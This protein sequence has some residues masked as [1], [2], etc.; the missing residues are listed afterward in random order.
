M[1]AGVQL[2]AEVLELQGGRLVIVSPVGVA[3]EVE[4]RIQR[5]FNVANVC[6]AHIVAEF[7]DAD[8]V[9]L[10]EF[11]RIADAAKGLCDSFEAFKAA[12]RLRL[13]RGGAA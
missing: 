8:P 11:R 9:R 4:G 1:S 5:L 3:E 12:A 7:G 13:S 2:Y 6:A 10:A